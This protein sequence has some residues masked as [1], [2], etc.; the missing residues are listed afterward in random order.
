MIHRQNACRS[1]GCYEP[2]FFSLGVDQTFTAAER[3]A[4]CACIAPSFSPE[5]AAC[6]V[7]HVAAMQATH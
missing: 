4:S 3:R 2:L 1:S 5:A 7:A 6:F